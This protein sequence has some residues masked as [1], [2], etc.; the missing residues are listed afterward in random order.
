[1]KIDLMYIYTDRSFRFCF[2][3]RQMAEAI[4]DFARVQLSQDQNLQVTSSEISLL[5][6]ADDPYSG[7]LAQQFAENWRIPTDLTPNPR[8]WSQRIPHNVGILNQPNR[9]ESEARDH[10]LKTS[11]GEAATGRGRELL[12]I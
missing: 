4:C 7:D 6:W 9:L 8:V 2:T 11:G 3:N 10:L 5:S 12:V 1:G